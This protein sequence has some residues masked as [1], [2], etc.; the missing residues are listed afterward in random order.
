MT[1]NPTEDSQILAFTRRHLKESL[2]VHPYSL[3]AYDE[4]I[5]FMTNSGLF[6]MQALDS[7]ANYSTEYV[8][9]INLSEGKLDRKMEDFNQTYKNNTRITQ[10]RNGYWNH[11]LVSYASNDSTTGNPDSSFAVKIGKG[12]EFTELSYITQVDDGIRKYHYKQMVPFSN[13]LV[14][15][16]DNFLSKVFTPDSTPKRSD[17]CG[18]V[19]SGAFDLNGRVPFR[20][21]LQT[22]LHSVNMA[23]WLDI[24]KVYIT[25]SEGTTV[26]DNGETYTLSAYTTGL[27]RATYSESGEKEIMSKDVV[28]EY[29]STADSYTSCDSE[30]VTCDST[31]V[32][33]DSDEPSVVLMAR[34]RTFWCKSS[35]IYN[36]GLKMYDDETEGFMD[37]YGWGC[38]YAQGKFV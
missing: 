31:T 30:V 26:L 38:S 9:P 16:S 20:K 24:D 15:I 14:M 22:G 27:A 10:I 1:G 37:F 35:S 32:T 33:C 19:T 12:A 29:Q 5:M 18:Q 3:C 36:I 6:A 17:Y 11:L 13:Y 25:A 7:S 21:Q 23:D 28:Y 34:Q 2:D 8:Q 4:Y